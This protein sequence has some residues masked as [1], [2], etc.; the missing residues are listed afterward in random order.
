ME[1]C[2]GQAF[3]HRFS[4]AAAETQDL[5]RRFHLRA[6]DGVCVREL[7]E[8]EHRNLHGIVGRGAPESG[9]VAQIL[10]LRSQHDPGCQVHHGDI[11][12]LG[13]IRNGAGRPGVHLNH[14]EFAVEDQILDIHESAR[15]QSQCQFLRHVTDPVQEAIRQIVGWVDRDGVA[16]VHPGPLNVFHDSRN[17][18]VCAIRD[19]VYLQFNAGHVLVYQDGIL[20]ATGKNAAHIGFGGFAV[21]GDAHVLAADNVAGT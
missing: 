15:A 3:V 21:P 1:A 4:E 2:S 8:G 18:H 10:Q 17:Q 13:N 14:I 19:H 20:D 9:A 7:L 16:A 5:A 12:H 11:C 6:E